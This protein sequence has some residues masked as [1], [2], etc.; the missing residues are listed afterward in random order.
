MKDPVIKI[1]LPVHSRARFYG[2]VIFGLLIG[3]TMRAALPDLA[4]LTVLEWRSSLNATMNGLCLFER[5][6]LPQFLSIL[7][8]WY[9]RG[10]R[11][12]KFDFAHLEAATPDAAK[13]LNP[14]EIRAR[15][16]EALR[17]ALIDF[18]RRNPE[19]PLT[20]FNGFGGDMEGTSAPIRQTVD[21]RWLLA[22]DTIYCGDPRPSDVPAMNF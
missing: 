9:D 13:K 14:S 4:P 6:F 7:Q 20:A 1:A 2:A 15:N 10:V 12:F 8:Y 17:A 19:V 3:G 21:P 22:F 11:M 16:S 18:R 5:G